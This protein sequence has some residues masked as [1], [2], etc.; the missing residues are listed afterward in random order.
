M[1]IYKA[2]YMVYLDG[3]FIGIVEE[4]DYAWNFAEDY[5]NGTPAQLHLDDIDRVYT[6]KIDVNRFQRDY[7]SIVDR[8]TNRSVLCADYMIAE[9]GVEHFNKLQLEKERAEAKLRAMTL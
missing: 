4:E 2:V 3:I 9:F 6:R 8:I 7:K 5:S 1:V